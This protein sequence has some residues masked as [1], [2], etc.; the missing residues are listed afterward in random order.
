MC[1]VR[2][3]AILALLLMAPMLATPTSAQGGP[4]CGDCTCSTDQCCKKSWTG[5]CS[6]NNCPVT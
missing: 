1:I 3:V 4:T 2:N 5:S 6:C